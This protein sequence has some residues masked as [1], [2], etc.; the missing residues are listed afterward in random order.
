ME[1][2][3]RDATRR[4]TALAQQQQ[5]YR[6]AVARR[7]LGMENANQGRLNLISALGKNIFQQ[8]QFNNTQDYNNRLINL[9]DRQT[10][11]DE[12]KFARDLAK[13]KDAAKQPAQTYSNSD[14]EIQPT[15][16]PYGKSFGDRLYRYAVT[17]T[18]V[19]EHI[20]P[21]LYLLSAPG[22]PLTESNRQY[23]NW[24]NRLAPYTR[25]LIKPIW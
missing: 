13:D 23:N 6:E 24:W 25:D 19:Y 17:K 20:R 4:Q 5:A 2:G 12:K 10:D 15:Y 21:S 11:L 7:L 3:D 16:N 14:A 18:P 22:Y 9:Y 8:Q 1:A